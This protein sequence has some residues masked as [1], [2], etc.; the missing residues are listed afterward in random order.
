MIIP[1][2]YQQV[3]ALLFRRNRLL[4]LLCFAAFCLRLF[5]IDAQSLWYDEGYS[6]WLST[7]SLGQVQPAPRQISTHRYI[8]T[9]CISG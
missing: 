7:Q 8:I 3:H 6:A 9:C 2:R 4:L 5:H 1:S